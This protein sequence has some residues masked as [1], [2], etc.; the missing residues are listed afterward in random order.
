MVLENARENWSDYPERLRRAVAD[1]NTWRR[2]SVIRGVCAVVAISMT[3]IEPS[4]SAS[5]GPPTPRPCANC[6]CELSA[7]YC[8][9]C[10]QHRR[11]SER[12][13]VCE[14]ITRSCENLLS[15]DSAFLGTFVGLF[16]RPGELCREYVQG[17]R[18]RYMNPFAYFVLA[19]T[20]N[21]F[22]STVVGWFT[23]TPSDPEEE[24]IANHV[25]WIMLAMLIPLAFLWRSLFRR[26][27][28]NLAE[29]Y[30][31][32]LYA[33]AQYVWLETIVLLPL[34]YLVPDLVLAIVYVAVWLAYMTFAA[35]RFYGEPA[36]MVGLKVLASALL[37]ALCVAG[38]AFVVGIVVY[39]LD[40]SAAG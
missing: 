11:G 18:K 28:D 6:G 32:A 13:Q 4:A 27:G 17:Q 37:F 7:P 30:V 40:S 36:L 9:N 19:G 1:R 21:L 8:A 35:T 22:V 29:N 38:I 16:R 12:L 34:P 23:G 20:V 31:F 39:I 14:I 24:F 26:S 10:G 3:A 33:L 25:L 2:K 5:S 15:F